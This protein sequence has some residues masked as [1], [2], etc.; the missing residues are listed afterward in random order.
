MALKIVG[1]GLG[2]TGTNSLKVALETL[3][4]GPCYHMFELLAHQERLPD[5]ERAAQ[6]GPMD[7]DELFDGYVATVDWPG[8]AYWRELAAANPDA[9][10]LLSVRD[11]DGWWA[12]MESTIVP[13]LSGPPIPG[14]PDGGR[15]QA[16]ISEMFRTRFTE[17]WADRDGAIAAYE[18][19]NDAVRREVPAQRLIEWRTGE[20]WEPICEGLGVPVP[21]TPFPHENSSGD[22]AE[23]VE[24]HMA[25]GTG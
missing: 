22:F 20:G 2:R 7:W 19:H 3:L 8:C 18:A 25:P 15:G 11:A 14:D 16:M 5:W 17:D 4:G 21:A 24:R 12:S 9:H 23:N 1:A 10:V 13:I 6:G